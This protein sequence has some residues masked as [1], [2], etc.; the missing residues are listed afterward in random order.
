M[1]WEKERLKKLLDERVGVFS[2]QNVQELV[3]ICN[4]SR[5]ETTIE[6]ELINAADGS[7]RRLLLGGQFLLEEY[8]IRTRGTGRI[9]KADWKLAMEQIRQVMP[10]KV[11][12]LRIQQNLGSVSIGE[13]II[14]LPNLQ[15]KIIVVLA[16]AAN[17]ISN[18]QKIIEKVWD[19]KQGGVTDEAIDQHISRIRK[20]LEK[21]PKNPVYLIT[22][23]DNGFQLMNYEIVN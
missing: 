10:V 7:P 13:R 1:E 16:T 23:R 17:G 5:N 18:R 3:Q 22:L 21:D 15:H 2:N 14:K 11:P 8:R 20:A 9:D 19:A 6:E 12:V 4:E